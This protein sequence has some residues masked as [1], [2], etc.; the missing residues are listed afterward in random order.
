MRHGGMLVEALHLVASVVAFAAM[1]G[2]AAWAYPQGYATI[3]NIGFVTMA[4]VAAM[5]AVELVKAWRREQ[6][7]TRDG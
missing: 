4:A 5:S 7:A 3:W 6:A 2:A 1:F